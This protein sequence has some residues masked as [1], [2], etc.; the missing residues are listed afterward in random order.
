VPAGIAWRDTTH[1]GVGV[2]VP[3]HL[4]KPGELVRE[5]IIPVP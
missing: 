2:P 3:A 5:Q 1:V 4:A